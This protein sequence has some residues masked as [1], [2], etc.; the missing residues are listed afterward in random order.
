LR[1][2]IKASAGH[3]AI[4]VCWGQK[5]QMEAGGPQIRDIIYALSS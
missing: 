4:V 1:F 3:D 5:L 2:L